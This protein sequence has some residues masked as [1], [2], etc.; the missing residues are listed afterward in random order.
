MFRFELFRAT[1][2]FSHPC[3]DES[4]RNE[5]VATVVER[6][7]NHAAVAFTANDTAFL[8]HL[9]AHIYFTDLGTGESD[10]ELFSD[11]RRHAGRRKIHADRAFLL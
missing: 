5:R 9:E 8:H 11:V 1:V 2:I 7:Q 4:C 6:R 10:T 3:E